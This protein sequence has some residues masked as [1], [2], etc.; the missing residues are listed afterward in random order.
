MAG[1]STSGA[2]QECQRTSMAAAFKDATSAF[3]GA[4]GAAA[5]FKGAVPKTKNNKMKPP[6]SYERRA[7]P[8]EWLPC[9]WT[10]LDTKEAPSKT[11]PFISIQSG[12]RVGTRR[13]DSSG[14]YT[15]AC[16]LP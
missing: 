7:R 12:L 1:A 9:A 4:A 8:W 14:A 16:S 11:R 13:S 15:A 10:R 5:A 3:K 6:C 2:V